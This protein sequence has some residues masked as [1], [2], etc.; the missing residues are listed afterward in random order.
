MLRDPLLVGAIPE[1]E[2]YV[3]LDGTNRRL[4][5]QH[6]DVP[7]VMVQVIDYADHQNVE[8][9]TW[10]HAASL[11]IDE[12]LA[13]VERIPGVTVSLLSPLAAPDVLHTPGTLAVLLDRR[14]RYGISLVPGTDEPRARQLRRLVDLYEERMV[15]IDCDLDRI[16]EEAGRVFDTEPGTSTLVAFPPFSRAQVVAMAMNETLIPAGITRHMILGGRVL[17]VNLPLDVLRLE[18][19][20]DAAAEA[21]EAH[22]ASLH[23]RMYREPTILF[24]S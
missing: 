9:R 4:A 20:I 8:L 15:R 14:R 12:I 10:C 11:P 5:L 23:P 22:L 21:F 16:E 13:D 6:L 7:G 1:I 18:S 24:D 3:L 2:G 17:R 19:G